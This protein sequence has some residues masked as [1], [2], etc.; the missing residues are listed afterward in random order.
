MR[1]AHRMPPLTE[2]Q[3]RHLADSYPHNHDWRIVHGE[4]KACWQLRRR[5]KRIRRLY[6]PRVRSLLDLS[7]CKG[8]FVLDAA[9]SGAERVVGLDVHAPDIAAS[10]A[11]LDVL[12]FPDV[13]LRVAHLHDYV[14]TEP[15]PFDVVLLVNTY[16]YLF[17]GSRREPHAYL[18]HEQIFDHTAKLVRPGGTFVFGNRVAFKRLPGNVKERALE[19]GLEGAYCEDAIRAAAERHFRIEEHGK[20]GRIPLWKLVRL[21]E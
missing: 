10:R 7:S 15:A 21:G 9:R 2:E 6:P 14:A 20:L 19:L 5:A 3:A 12:G 16:Q 1:Y 18:D 17:Y 4:P 11:A 13:D 8:W